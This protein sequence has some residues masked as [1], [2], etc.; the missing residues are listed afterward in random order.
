MNPLSPIQRW[1]ISPATD[2]Q[3]SGPAM[4]KIH[5]SRAQQGSST[6]RWTQPSGMTRWS[7]DITYIGEAPANRH[8][9]PPPLTHPCTSLGKTGKDQAFPVTYEGASEGAV[10]RDGWPLPLYKKCHSS[11]AS[12]RWAVS[13]GVWSSPAALWTDG[14][15]A[16]LDRTA[17]H[18][19]LERSSIAG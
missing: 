7:C 4:Q 16:S 13:S 9:T 3:R 2:D 11:S 17:D 6:L 1:M 14:S 12:F 19:S 18:P 15:S 8:V 5:P 10:L